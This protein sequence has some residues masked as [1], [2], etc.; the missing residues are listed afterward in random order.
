[1]P[2]TLVCGVCAL[3]LLASLPASASDS[4][5]SVAASK[6]RI[7]IIIDDLGYGLAIGRRAVNL[8]GPV[9]CAVLPET[10]RGRALAE[11]ASR[12]GKEVLLH[13]PLQSQNRDAQPEPGGISMDMS[14]DQL[15]RA[16]AA[17]LESVPHVVGVSNHRGSL[18]TRHPGHMSWLMQEIHAR[19]GLFFVDSFTT[20]ESVALG[21]AHETGV[22][23]VRRDVFLDNE[24]TPARLAGEFARLKRLA[25]RRGMAIGIGHPHPETLSFLEQALPQLQAEGIELISISDFVKLRGD[26]VAD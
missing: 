9:A 16:F 10:P 3:L 1:V 24:R 13:L 26:G 12:N 7:A 4:V 6:P 25:R 20:L 5:S 2:A 19:D 11:L 21:I 15:S 22:A 8:P 18:L 17:S 14:R 23:A